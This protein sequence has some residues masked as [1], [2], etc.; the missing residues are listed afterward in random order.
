M[1][2]TKG[3]W[4]KEEAAA[5]ALKARNSAGTTIQDELLTLDEARRAQAGRIAASVPDLWMHMYFRTLRG[6]DGLP[7]AVKMMCYHC[8]GWEGVK[9]GVKGCTSYGCPLWA[10]RP[11]Q[12]DKDE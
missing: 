8:V 1:A 12:E 6:D 11:G 7:T 10:Y 9:E 3:T 2:H 4:T 5:A